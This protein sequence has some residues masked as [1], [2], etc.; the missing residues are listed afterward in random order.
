VIIVVHGWSVHLEGH[1]FNEGKCESPFMAHKANSR[2]VYNL[3]KNHQV[4]VLSLVLRTLEMVV[5]IILKF[6]LLLI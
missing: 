6:P 4:M 5:Q 2:L 3:I 1:V